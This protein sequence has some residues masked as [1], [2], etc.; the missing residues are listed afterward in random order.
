[1]RDHV[2]YLTWA[3]EGYIR[4]TPGNVIDHAK[5]KADFEEDY[6]K[7][8]IQEVAFDRWGFEALRQQFIAEGVNEDVFVSFGMGYVSMSAPFKKF[9]EL[10]LAGELA[11]G[12]NPVFR[13]MA[14]NTSAE[15]DSADNVK[16][17][18]KKS[19]ERIDG[20]VST[21]MALGRAITIPEVKPSVYET[22]GIIELG[23]DES[24]E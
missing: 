15:M 13:W 21:T 12:G 6:Q 19:T 18:K 10:I 24:N 2:P 5:I 20:I 8:D 7:F 1:M 9:D 3:R 4:L 14:G 23:E 16:P 11:H 17:S 22:R